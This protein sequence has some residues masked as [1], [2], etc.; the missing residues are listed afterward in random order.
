MGSCPAENCALMEEKSNL[1][2]S[3]AKLPKHLRWNL[4]RPGLEIMVFQAA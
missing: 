2:R 3:V 1:K 4:D